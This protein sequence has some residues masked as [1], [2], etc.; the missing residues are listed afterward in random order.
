MKLQYLV[1]CI[2]LITSCKLG[3]QKAPDTSHVS[4]ASEFGGTI[5]ADY[6]QGNQCQLSLQGY[7]ASSEDLEKF[8]P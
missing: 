3:D 2:A 8:K 6:K 5:C 1:I 7:I 4:Y